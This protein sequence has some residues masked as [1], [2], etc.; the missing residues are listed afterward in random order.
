MTN[1][2]GA[3]Q[4]STKNLVVLSRYKHTHTHT[5]LSTTKDFNNSIY[6]LPKRNFDEQA[7]TEFRC[8]SLEAKLLS[9]HENYTTKQ[10]NSGTYQYGT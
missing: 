3:P 9:P 8:F 4:Y 2:R 10:V 5:D 6:I 1:W 7:E